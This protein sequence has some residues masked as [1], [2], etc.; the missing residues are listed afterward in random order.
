MLCAAAHALLGLAAWSEGEL[1]VAFAQ[2][3]VDWEGLRTATRQR[4]PGV[5]F[6]IAAR[7]ERGRTIDRVR[8]LREHHPREQV[9]IVVVFSESGPRAVWSSAFTV[10]EA[11]LGATVLLH[12]AAT[13]GPTRPGGVGAARGTQHR[14]CRRI[15]GE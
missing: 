1:D 2:H 5:T 12:P 6:V 15:A 14:T 13:T 11:R 7:T 8:A 9:E 3:L 4:P 10:L